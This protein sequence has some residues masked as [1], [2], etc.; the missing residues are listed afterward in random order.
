MKVMDG[1]WRG[2]IRP[3]H[4]VI[5]HPLDRQRRPTHSQRHACHP[6]IPIQENRVQNLQSRDKSTTRNTLYCEGLTLKSTTLLTRGGLLR[7]EHLGY[8][9]GRRRQLPV[10]H[11]PSFHGRSRLPLP[12]FWSSPPSEA[13]GS[14]EMAV[15][16]IASL[17]VVGDCR[18]ENPLLRWDRL[19]G[20]TEGMN[21]N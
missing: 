8:R 18:Q 16:K 6:A 11:P 3:S 4:C 1:R 12:R 15:A 5:E 14:L 19:G 7:L 9:G 2:A 13:W 20:G 21:R 17:G 10:R